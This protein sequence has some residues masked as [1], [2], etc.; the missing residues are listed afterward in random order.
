MDQGPW[1][2]WV[3]LKG[4]KEDTGLKKWRQDMIHS[5]TPRERER[6]REGGRGKE[7]GQAKLMLKERRNDCLKW[8]GPRRRVSVTEKRVR[9]EDILKQRMDLLEKYL[10]HYF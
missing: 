4:A 9:S 6:E 5:G 3:G 7:R 8:R 1:V 2:I 10:S